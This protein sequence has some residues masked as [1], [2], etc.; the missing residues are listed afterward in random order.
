M[1]EEPRNTPFGVLQ[2]RSST[3]MMVTPAVDPEV[4]VA[5]LKVGVMWA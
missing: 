5:L 2:F 1:P 4:P 3:P